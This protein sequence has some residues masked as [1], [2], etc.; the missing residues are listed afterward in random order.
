[1]TCTS[2][3]PSRAPVAVRRRREDRRGTQS[4]CI[5]KRLSLMPREASTNGSV[6]LT[7]G[8]LRRHLEDEIVSLLNEKET[9]I[10]L[11]AQRLESYQMKARVS[12]DSIAQCQRYSQKLFKS[13]RL[14]NQDFER[15]MRDLQKTI[16]SELVKQTVK[17]KDHEVK[18]R[19]V[20]I[21][22]KQ[23]EM[24]SRIEENHAARA[25]CVEK[26]DGDLALFAVLPCNL[27]LKVACSVDLLKSQARA[28]SCCIMVALSE[29]W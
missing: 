5:L 12:L 2:G 14:F 10:Q 25:R 28:E 23:L 16:Q 11:L 6:H 8:T 20:G 4:Y 9:K 3:A 29:R 19:L 7:C 27:I 1:M 22:R 18:S 13:L 15:E 17:A 24:S 21:L 26:A